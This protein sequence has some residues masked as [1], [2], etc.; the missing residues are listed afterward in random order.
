MKLL[1][2]ASDYKIGLS[3]LLTEQAIAMQNAD[4]NP[5]CLAGENEQEAGLSEKLQAKKVNLVRLDGLD[6]HLKFKKL[7]SKIGFIIQKN[8]ITHVH[9]Q[10]NWQL[11]LVAFYKYKNILPK[12]FK[13]IYTLHGFRHND[14]IKSVI[15]VLIIGILLF[16][17]ADTIIVMSNYARK[18]FFLLS[19]KI[20]KLYLGIDNMYFEKEKNTIDTSSL[21]LIFPA[22]FRKGK[23]QHILINAISH[24]IDQTHDSTIQLYL[25]GSGPLLKMYEKLVNENN[26]RDNIIFPGQCTKTQIKELY[27][28]CNIAVI[29]SNSETFGQ[30]IVE[31]FV[32]GRPV[33]TR[34]VGIATDIIIAGKNGFFFENEKDLTE[35][36]I[37]FS[38]NKSL[39]KKMGN[40]NFSH[41]NIFSWKEIIG[42]Y[43]VINL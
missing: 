27:E 6:E 8:Q 10:N 2:F 15:A 33:L 18:R 14:V 9:V 43:C 42:K 38:K 23:N 28:S 40:T 37:Y 7:S 22:Q 5:V 36:L 34:R 19:Y 29:S 32:L 39:L 16:L 3:S 30:S 26:L 11:V 17:F 35:Y 4:M 25:P 1:F 21:K 41:R 12:H 31:P 20:K 24:Y 13:I